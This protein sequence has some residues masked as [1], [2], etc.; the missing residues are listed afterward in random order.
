MTPKSTGSR[1]QLRAAQTTAIK[2]VARR[3]IAEKGVTDLSLREVSREMGMVSSALY[4]YFATRD[5]LLTALIYDAYN[6][7]GVVVER[8][9][10]R[11][12]RRDTRGRWRAACLAVRRWART[13]PHE[14][15]L[16]FGTPVPGYVA[17]NVTIAA[18]TR[19]PTVLGRILSD[20]V[21]LRAD[22]RPE[23]P[24]PTVDVRHFLQV[25]ALAPSMPN[26]DPEHFVRALLVWTTLFGAVSFELFGHYEGSVTNY[27]RMFDRVIEELA[28][29]VGLD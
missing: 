28:D 12:V 14:Y 15:A 20:H 24:R 8:A 17:P 2:N 22:S 1:A 5:E 13:H 6:E 25:D 19:V 16:L 7:L 10:S 21:E 4:R 3:L 27:P 9:E 26:V 29:F 11:V 23:S 18:A